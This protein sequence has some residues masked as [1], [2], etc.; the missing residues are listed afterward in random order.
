MGGQAYVWLQSRPAEVLTLLSSFV[1]QRNDPGVNQREVVLVNI[2]ARAI[3]KAIL[4]VFGK[5]LRIEPDGCDHESL[6]KRCFRDDVG[7]MEQLM[8]VMDVC[9]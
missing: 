1:L 5:M 9:F 6:Q 8:R 7:T 4:Q 2:E 3:K